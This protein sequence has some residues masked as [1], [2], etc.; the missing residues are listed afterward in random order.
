MN[1]IHILDVEIMAEISKDLTKK[2][3]IHQLSKSIKKHYAPT[4][5]AV[6]R[7]I[8]EEHLAKNQ[9]NLIEPKLKKTTLLEIGEKKRLEEQSKEIRIIAKK[10]NTIKNSFFTAILFGSSTHKKGKDID[11]L[12]IIPDS[13]NVEEFTKEA[14]ESLSAFKSETDLQ[15]IQEK[16]C[17]EMLNQPNQLNVLNEL[18]KNHLVLI[19]TENFYRIIKRWKHAD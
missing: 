7:L 16:S 13:E 12:I 3:S 4:H 17:Y 8:K 19:G 14:E 1:I 15:V 10:L 5:I 18:L 11:I 9:N 2:W 6:Q